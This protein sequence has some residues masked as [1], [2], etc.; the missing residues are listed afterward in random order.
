MKKLFFTF[1]VIT[2]SAMGVFAQGV[3]GGLKG[4]VNF[5]NQ[6]YDGDFPSPDSRTGFHAGLYLNVA[7]SEILSLQPEFLYNSVGAEL[8]N[9][10]FKTDYLSVPIL[11]K[12]NPIPLFNI[13]AGPQF[14]FLMNAKFDDDDVK[15]ALKG[16][17]IGLGVG[18]GVDLPM[19]LG[20][21]ARYVFG[22]SDINDTD[23]IVNSKI[24]NR[25]FQV[26]ATFRL[27]GE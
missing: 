10:D 27:F 14:G 24:T 17:D 15:D 16:M 12:F 5:A 7:F 4:G 21:T 19:G 2:F 8:N 18:A 11:I 25:V 23:D 20:V 3:S 6:N 22:L 26:S 9:T 13:H 1:S